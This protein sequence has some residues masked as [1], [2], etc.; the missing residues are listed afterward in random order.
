[1]T[2]DLQFKKTNVQFW[3]QYWT[4]HQNYSAFSAIWFAQYILLFLYRFLSIVFDIFTLN[5]YTLRG[6]GNYYV[7]PILVYVP[8]SYWRFTEQNKRARY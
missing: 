6:Y 4:K 1:M 5:F 3:V 2:L 8:F 7:N